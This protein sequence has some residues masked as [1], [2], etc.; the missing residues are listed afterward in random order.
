MSRKIAILC[1]FDGTIAERDVGHHFFGTFIADK[2]GWNDLV[3]RWKLGLISSRECLEREFERLDADRKDL[4]AFIN[5]EK[6]DQY[7]K[8]FVDFCNKRKFDIL[9]VS[10]GLDYYIERMLM[11]SGLGYLDYK[12]NRLIMSNG[13]LSGIEFPY[14]NTLE[15]TRCGNCKRRHLEKLKEEGC[16]VVYI[17]NGL[18][19]RCPVEYAELVFAKGELLEHCEQEE[20]AC[21]PFS[22]FRDIE[23]E[24]TGRFLL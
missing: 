12:A 21:I 7:F 3:D 20:I 1:D 23:R 19:D 16:F 8:D 13:N 17:G 14:Y 2:D 9:I 4:D 22:N 5:N 11:N 18:S 24:L 6:L 10:D 15:C